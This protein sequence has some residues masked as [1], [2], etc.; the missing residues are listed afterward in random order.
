MENK[1]KQALLFLNK[2]GL[3]VDNIET[4]TDED[5]EAILQ[6]KAVYYKLVIS[7]NQLKSGE[8][9]LDQILFYP[10]KYAFTRKD[11]NGVVY[12]GPSVKKVETG[13]IQFRCCKDIE[14]QKKSS[15]DQI[16]N[17]KKNTIQ[18]IEI[19]Y[20]PHDFKLLVEDNINKFLAGH[21]YSKIDTIR[22]LTAE[23]K[24]NLKFENDEE[25]EII[26]EEKATRIQT[27]TKYLGN[28]FYN[29]GNIKVE[30]EQVEINAN[31]LMEYLK[32]KNKNLDKDFLNDLIDKDK[33]KKTKKDDGRTQ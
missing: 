17:Y 28:N 10:R 9:I 18:T 13:E 27:D 23:E 20:T 14:S 8:Q 1:R 15:V 24:A 33:T 26:D 6:V 11:K 19:I 21:H 25:Y 5:I 3:T 2:R 22:P 29:K 12:F 31:K 7:I 4:L 32:T 16:V 30:V